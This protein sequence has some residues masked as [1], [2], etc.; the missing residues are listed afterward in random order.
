MKNKAFTLIELLVVIVI[1]GLLACLIIPTMARARESARRAMC[2]N[3]LRQIGI[4]WHL[5][6]DEHN[7]TFPSGNP[8]GII[9]I[10][11]RGP[12]YYS[13]SY[14]FG[15]KKGKE[16]PDAKWPANVRLLNPYLQIYSE[17]DKAALEVFHCPSDIKIFA[18]GV[19]FF[20]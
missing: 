8:Y 3:N 9:G 15:G 13:I 6:L 2:A 10:G 14:T 18:E 11:P 1:V 12:L 19:N 20:G 5:Y 17:A 4:G 16:F 7:D